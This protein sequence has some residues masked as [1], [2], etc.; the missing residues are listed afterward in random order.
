MIETLS[1][2]WQIVLAVVPVVVFSGF[3]HGALG[4]GFPMVATPVIAVFL[5]VKLAILITL[6]PTAAVNIASIMSQRSGW[7]GL[8][9]Y[10]P[11]AA[12]SLAGAVCGSMVLAIADAAPFKLLLAVLI[13]VFLMTGQQGVWPE[14]WFRLNS[15]WAMLLTG[16]LAGFAAGTTNV[17]VAVLIVYFLTLNVPRNEMVPAMNLCFLLGKLAQIVVFYWANLLSLS[18]ALAT[19]PLAVCAVVSLR[20][21]QRAG[22]KL[23]QERYRHLL[24]VLLAV[25]ATI[26]LLQFGLSLL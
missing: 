4:M 21:G 11:L 22:A 26:L 16:L 12:A 1:L 23:P 19:A 15:M 9:R 14:R 20:V 8:K 5:D 2:D 10:Q 3:V 25:L 7:S 24:R 17:M 18:L 13:L 6:L